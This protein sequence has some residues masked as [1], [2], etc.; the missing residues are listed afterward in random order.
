M[1]VCSLRRKKT[2]FSQSVLRNGHFFYY[3]GG[4]RRDF[5]DFMISVEYD[6]GIDGAKCSL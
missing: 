3:V 4:F 5:N 1:F 2:I 6:N